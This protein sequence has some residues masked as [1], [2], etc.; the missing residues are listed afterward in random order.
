MLIIFS[1]LI[2]TLFL[3]MIASKLI[4]VELSLLY[5]VGVFWPL[6]VGYFWGWLPLKLGALIFRA[7]SILTLM[8]FVAVNLWLPLPRI[9]EM[10]YMPH[11][12]K[13]EQ[14]SPLSGTIATVVFDHGSTMFS[15]GKLM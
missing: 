9:V 8:A 7:G 3:G 6:G 5:L 15:D 2:V 14:V 13:G 12:V 11:E 1:F 4:S 10:S